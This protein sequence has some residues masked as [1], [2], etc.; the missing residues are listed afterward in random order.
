MLGNVRNVENVGLDV[1]Y[2]KEKRKDD[3]FG[4]LIF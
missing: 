2:I 1:Y 3:Q 4:R